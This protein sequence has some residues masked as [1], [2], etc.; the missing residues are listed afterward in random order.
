MLVPIDDGADRK[1]KASAPLT[2]TTKG[3]GHGGL[4]LGAC[5]LRQW[6]DRPIAI[7]G[8]LR[9]RAYPKENL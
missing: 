9:A 5:N 3:K 6:L 8:T 2:A 1:N 4:K 7:D